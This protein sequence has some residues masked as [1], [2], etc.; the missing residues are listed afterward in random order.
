MLKINYMRNNQLNFRSISHLEE[1]EA[2]EILN[3]LNVTPTTNQ[4][5]KPKE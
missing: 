2:A 5:N 1:R 3:Q 4:K